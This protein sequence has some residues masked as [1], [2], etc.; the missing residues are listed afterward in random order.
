[1][2]VN[3]IVDLMEIEIE[4]GLTFAQVAKTSRDAETKA[5]SLDNARK[6]YGVVARFLATNDFTDSF[7]GV[8]AHRL[9]VLG[10]RIAELGKAFETRAKASPSRGIAA[11]PRAASFPNTL[12]CEANPLTCHSASLPVAAGMAKAKGS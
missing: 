5:R 11:H 4:L 1:M 9:S 10:Q 7:G 8:I 12:A 6:A 2:P 3:S